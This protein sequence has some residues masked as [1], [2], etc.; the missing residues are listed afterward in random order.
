[1]AAGE[2]REGDTSVVMYWVF[3]A[4]LKPLL[5]LAYGIRVEG[6]ENVP[7]RG[8][9]IVAANHVSFL[10][11]FFIP[12]VIKWRKVT[13]LAK[14]DYFKSPKTSWFFTC[15]GQIP[16]EREGGKKSQQSLEIALEVLEEGKLLGIYPEGTR[17]PDGRLHRGRTGV[18]RLALAAKTPVIP[19]GLVGTD[20]VM[21]KNRKYP[22]LFHRGRRIGVVVRFGKPLDFSRFEGRE[23]DRFA[24]RSVTD[25][26]VYEIMQ[27]SG[28]EYVDEYASRT[29][30][31]PLPESTRP[32][33][34]IDLAD[35]ALVG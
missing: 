15:A 27:L 19:C 5:K 20:V 7:R 2:G 34:D 30:T 26:I 13:Y 8:A 3:K 22:R 6:L 31:E 18:A 21:P 4:V 23:R 35:E 32:V 12:L 17:S 14:A 9:A 24:L 33:D 16:C 25:E 29:A 28:Q 1:M 10:D 11:S